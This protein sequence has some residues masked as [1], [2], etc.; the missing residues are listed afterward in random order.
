[1]TLTEP[2]RV[3]V[4]EKI[5]ETGVDMLR[6]RFDVDVGTDWSRE[7]LLEKIG[8]LPRHPDPLGDQARRRADRARGQAAA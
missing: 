4:A 2:Y 1:M 8:V 3:L 5:A 7:D 6:E